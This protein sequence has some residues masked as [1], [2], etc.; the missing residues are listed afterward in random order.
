MSNVILISFCS[1]ILSLGAALPHNHQY[2][3][4]S[5]PV[6][7]KT[8]NTTSPQPTLSPF[9]N[10]QQSQWSIGDIGTVVF[11]CIASI[12]GAVAVLLTIWLGRR[13][14]GLLGR[15]GTCSTLRCMSEILTSCH[16]VGNRPSEEFEL[17]ETT[18]GA[19]DLP[20]E[21]FPRI[22]AAESSVVDEREELEGSANN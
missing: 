18:L 8:T 17:N 19:N 9:Y 11:G 20:L 1:G 5:P 2:E 22:Q 3:S 14:N 15:H 13:H 4:Q 21:D 7:S 6:S 12:L 10:Q 16:I